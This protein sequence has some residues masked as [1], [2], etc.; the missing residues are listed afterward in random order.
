MIR[1]KT[2]PNGVRIVTE[3]VDSV[4]SAAI[5]LW[6]EVGSAYETEFN[7]GVSHC[8]E[9]MLFK[10]TTNRTADQIAEEMEDVGGMLGA[11]TSR[12]LTKVYG[13]VL[14]ED[15]EIALDVITDMVM[16]PLLKDDD[17]ALEKKVII[18]EMRMYEDDPGDV[19][20]E[21]VY[22]NLWKG[23]SYSL[24]ITGTSATVNSITT[25]SLRSHFERFYRPE[26]MIVSIAGKFDEEK[27]IAYLTEKLAKLP[28]SEEK[29]EPITPASRVF[30][31]IKER[32]IEQAQM[33]VS[34]EGL[35][36]TDKRQ[37]T[38]SVLE[39]CMVASSSSRL[40]KEVR[41]K[42]GLVYNIGGLEHS[43]RSCGLYGIYCATMAE[44]VEEVISLILAEFRRLKDEGFTAKEIERAKTQLRADLLMDLESMP[45]RST[46][47]A[48]DLLYFGRTIS[49]DECRKEIEEVTN[50]AVID[51]ARE[52]FV[53]EKLSLVALGPKGEL[54]RNL[55]LV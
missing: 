30:N 21:L 28:G 23:Y 47:N 35:T 11:A 42:R 26:R 39:L 14:G 31:I 10:G 46:S 24:P 1:T 13:H 33:I 50:E 8:L 9:H 27:T 7:N 6:V 20:Q 2:L 3:V 48:A 15:I 17:L 5:D 40:F 54:S 32:N 52:L 45:S 12:E 38:L 51:L 44:H 22:R 53:D 41:E 29:P 16:N 36:Q 4:Y 43:Y 25:S 19:A 34:M 37:A 49:I 18:D 55:S